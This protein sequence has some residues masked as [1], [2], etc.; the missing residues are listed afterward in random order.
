M[1]FGSIVC[2]TII[3]APGHPAE[4]NVHFPG[5]LSFFLHD[6][7]V[8]GGQNR[9][10]R[11]ARAHSFTLQPQGRSPRQPWETCTCLTLRE[12][13]MQ[14]VMHADGGLCMQMV[15]HAEAALCVAV[16]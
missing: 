6:H 8:F 16:W 14:W 10:G 4:Q 15:A 7:P 3:A 12:W 11:A 9:S 2:S 1:G 13:V 5:P